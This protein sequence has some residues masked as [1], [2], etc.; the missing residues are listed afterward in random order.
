MIYGATNA[1]ML[2]VTEEIR[3]LSGIGLDYLELCLDPPECTP[4]RI[5]AVLPE[6]RALADGEGLS[7]RVVHLPT[8]VWM[9]DVYP[10]I[11]EASVNETRLALEICA[12]LGIGKAVIHPGYLTGLVRFAPAI[13]RRFSLET[14]SRVLEEARDLGIVL[15]AENMFPRSGH[16]YRP[17]ELAGLLGEIPDLMMTL[18]LGHAN[19]GGPPDRGLRFVEACGPRIRHLHV[20]DNSGREDEHL[21]VGVGRAD[22]AG[23]LG[24]LKVAGYDETMTLEVFAPDRD[25]LGLSLTKIK[26][27]WDRV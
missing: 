25:Y 4:D 8:F 15:C 14:M 17:E 27:I 18:D 19:I 1:P 7:P 3:A 21:P 2:P 22:L 23:P 9:A 26:S 6:I 13:G 10:S 16:M 11:R 24:A 12:E 20:C 5:R